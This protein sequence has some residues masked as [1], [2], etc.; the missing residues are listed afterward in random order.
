MSTNTFKKIFPSDPDLLPEIEEYI[1]DIAEQANLN[2]EKYNN[3]ALSV[4]EAA[5][6][7]I[8]HGNNNDSSKNLEINVK[9]SD[10]VIE[11]TFKDQGKGFDL[12]NVADPT[13]PENILKDHGRGIHIMRS[14][15]DD[16]RYNFTPEGTEVT[17]VLELH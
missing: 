10:K 14:F 7:C 6:N 9:F 17:L 3:L 12:G 4:A 16:I 2:P 11:V 5:S 8:K 15:L 13:A 1:L